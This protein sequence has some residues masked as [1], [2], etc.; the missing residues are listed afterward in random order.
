MRQHGFTAHD[1]YSPSR[2]DVG[3]TA[4]NKWF[5]AVGYSQM[6]ER[7]LGAV[8]AAAAAVRPEP[9]LED[10]LNQW[11]RHTKHCTVCQKV[12]IHVGVW[13]VSRLLQGGGL[14]W[15]TLCWACTSNCGTLQAQR[16]NIPPNPSLY[17]V[18]Q[19]SNA[20]TQGMQSLET[21]AKACRIAAVALGIFAACL[22]AAAHALTP[23]AAAAGLAAV[24]AVVV[25][26]K[27]LQLRYER[28]INSI[29][30]W[31]RDGGL[32][33]VPGLPGPIQV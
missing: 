17:F 3:V 1:Y 25:A 8:A 7:R 22:C 30:M 29:N 15:G 9:S 23:G 2:A 4:A 27:L 20:H 10:L 19:P 5:D 21:A 12:R 28:F 26:G 16:T 6:W 14:R 32:S 24:G 13:W 33:L 31:Q 11:E 18:L